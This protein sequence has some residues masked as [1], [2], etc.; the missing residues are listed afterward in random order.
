MTEADL[1]NAYAGESMAHMRYL[2][3]AARAEKEGFKNTARLLRAIAFAEQVHATNH[4]MRMP[5][6]PAP[7]AGEAPFGLGTTS[8][9]LQYG[10]DGETFEINEMYPVYKETAIF[11]GEK[12]VVTSFDWALQTEKV[13]QRLFTDAKGAVDQGKDWKPSK[14]QI[15]ETCGYTME[16]EAPDVC[17]ICGAKKEGFK[18]F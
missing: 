10:I 7:M 1:H 2:I 6:T 5:R 14:V 12:A 8:Q 15:C 4:F 3:F 9:N 13:H 17:P 16:G 11:Q 18:E